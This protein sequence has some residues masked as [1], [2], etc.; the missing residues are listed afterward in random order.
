M[1]T[2]ETNNAFLGKIIRSL[3][4][5]RCEKDANLNNNKIKR[6]NLFISFTE[7]TTHKNV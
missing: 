4:T 2:E 3:I 7:E 1:L 5:A 6:K